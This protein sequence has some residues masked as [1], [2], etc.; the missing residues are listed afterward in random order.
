[1]NVEKGIIVCV[2]DHVV[3]KMNK[4]IALNVGVNQIDIN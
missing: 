1:M 2:G 4:T 3:M